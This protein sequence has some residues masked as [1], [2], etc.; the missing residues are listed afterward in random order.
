MSKRII[1][2]FLAVAMLFCVSFSAVAYDTADW[3]SEQEV[4]IVNLSDTISPQELTEIE[5]S[6]GAHIVMN[7]GRT[8]PIA[9]VVTVE[10]I[11][12]A[13]FST[14]ALSPENSYKVTVD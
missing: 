10:D 1:S 11:P 4:T 9:S 5:Q 7:D 8:V 2:L 12:P 14:Y 13:N 3:D 6:V